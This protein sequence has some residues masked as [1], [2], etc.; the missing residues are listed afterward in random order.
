MY[1]IYLSSSLRHGQPNA[2]GYWTGKNCTVLGELCPI[3]ES[4]ITESTKRYSSRRR[5]EDGLEA[6]LHRPYAYVVGGYIE[7]TQP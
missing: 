2:Y 5:A 6:C 7:E 1:V 4:K 3:T